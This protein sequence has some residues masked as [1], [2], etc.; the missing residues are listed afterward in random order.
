MMGV[1]GRKGCNLTLGFLLYPVNLLTTKLVEGRYK[2]RNVVTTEAETRHSV[3]QRLTMNQSKEQAR[4][5]ADEEGE[6]AVSGKT[7]TAKQYSRQT[8]FN[9]HLLWNQDPLAPS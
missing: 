2:E 9:E 7:H 4:E 8:G 6:E 5:D 1:K 3:F